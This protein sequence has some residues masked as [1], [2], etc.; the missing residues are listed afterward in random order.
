MIGKIKIFQ[1]GNMDLNKQEDLDKG[2]SF[3][4][5]CKFKLRGIK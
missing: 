4:K 2:I 5:E 3:L 1:I